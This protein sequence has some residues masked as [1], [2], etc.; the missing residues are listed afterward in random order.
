MLY[1]EVR[2]KRKHVT[3]LIFIDMTKGSSET[4]ETR[5]QEWLSQ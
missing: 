5:L 3:L 4:L 1:L 2:G